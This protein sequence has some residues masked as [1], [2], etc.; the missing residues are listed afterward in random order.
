MPPGE[1]PAPSATST[2]ASA[3]VPVPTEPWTPELDT[4]LTEYLDQ[5]KEETDCE[6]NKFK[7][8]V[9]TACGKVLVSKGFPDLKNKLLRE[10]WQKI[11]KN[12]AAEEATARADWSAQ[13]EAFLIEALVAAKGKALWS[14]NNFKSKAYTDAAKFLKSKGHRCTSKQA[15]ARWVRVS[16]LLI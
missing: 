13:A 2:S 10:R 11:C 1:N 14:D 3:A 7:A 16:L 12:R 4:A 5:V 9:F 8:K 15:K 6:S